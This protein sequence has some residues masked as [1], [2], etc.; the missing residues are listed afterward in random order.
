M[1]HILGYALTMQQGLSAL[2]ILGID[3][4]VFARGVTTTEHVSYDKLGQILG[5]Y[6][7]NKSFDTTSASADSIHSEGSGDTLEGPSSNSCAV[8]NQDCEVASVSSASSS[9]RT[10]HR[11]RHNV[12]ISRQ[13]LRELLV[14]RIPQKQIRWGMKLAGY[15]ESNGQI[16][17]T[18]SDGSVKLADLVVA[19]DGIY[20]LLRKDAAPQEKLKYLGLL[21]I[22]GI[23]ENRPSYNNET[24]PVLRKQQ[25]VDGETR[26]FSMPFDKKRTMWQLSFP[27]L[28]EQDALLSSSTSSRLHEMALNRC[29]DWH[30]PLVDLLQRT[31]IDMISGH[32]VYDRDPCVWR[33]SQ[34]NSSLLSP[35]NRIAFIG[36]AA[37]PMSPFKG[38]G[39]NQALADAVSI[40]ACIKATISDVELCNSPWM[41]E[42]KSKNDTAV[43][44]AKTICSD[45]DIGALISNAVTE[46]IAR[47]EREMLSRSLP[48]VLKSRTAAAYLH[49]DAALV[50][51]N[52]TRAAAAAR[53]HGELN[54]DFNEEL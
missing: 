27:V 38:Q 10:G 26:C 7:P 28:D 49:S 32:P 36:D 50:L 4:E 5:V 52:I 54:A 20:S 6:G 17:L 37:H 30:S 15:S 35:T 16:C 40:A 42:K 33:Q 51:G 23:T 18:F 46:S 48:K 3:R 22:L 44:A 9:T 47:Y 24:P 12:H 41:R 14:N 45:S 8:N 2:R 21:V 39:A 1:I 11:R 43:D 31:D 29:K 34:T 53:V 13:S 19:A 25:W